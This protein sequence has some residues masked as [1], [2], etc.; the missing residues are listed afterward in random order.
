M[1]GRQSQPSP[2]SSPFVTTNLAA[3]NDPLPSTTL[4]SGA[5]SSSPHHPQQQKAHLAW[6][7]PTAH[8]RYLAPPA[9]TSA[10]DEVTEWKPDTI[11]EEADEEDEARKGER[12]RGAADD[13]SALSSKY[14]AEDKSAGLKRSLIV[15]VHPSGP[16]APPPT[17]TPS[18]SSSLAAAGQSGVPSA[19]TTDDEEEDV[20]DSAVSPALSFRSAL[21][22]PVLSSVR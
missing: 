8:S 10:A 2:A 17:S 4:A 14:R 22:C 19:Q 16:P 13:L 6:S 21:R 3:D 1:G 5:S 9:P 11:T 12:A 20:D 15:A 7:A 18:S